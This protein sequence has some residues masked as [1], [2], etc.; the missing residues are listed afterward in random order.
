MSEYL[1]SVIAYENNHSLSQ[2]VLVTLFSFIAV[3]ILLLYISNKTRIISPS[4]HSI[5]GG[6]QQIESNFIT[7]KNKL[8]PKQPNAKAYGNY[9]D[10]YLDTKTTPQMALI[11]D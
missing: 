11:K 10:K 5:T 7:V 1:L 2:Y 3:N 4:T 8:K 9:V 6:Q